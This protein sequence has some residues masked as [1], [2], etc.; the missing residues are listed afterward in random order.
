M[1]E[2]AWPRMLG[3]K[4]WFAS[5]RRIAGPEMV[6]ARVASRMRG[7]KR[8]DGLHGERLPCLLGQKGRL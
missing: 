5:E 4:R 6:M 3:Q 1:L 8:L 7:Q 2:T